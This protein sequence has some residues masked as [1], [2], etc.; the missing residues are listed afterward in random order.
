MLAQWPPELRVEV[1]NVSRTPRYV[2]IERPINNYIPNY[3]FIF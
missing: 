2:I 1:L 3:W